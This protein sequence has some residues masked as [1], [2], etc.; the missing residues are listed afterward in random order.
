MATEGLQNDEKGEEIECNCPRGK[1]HHFECP[2]YNPDVIYII[3]TKDDLSASEQAAQQKIYSMYKN[4]KNIPPEN[5]G[6]ETA[7]AISYM[8]HHTGCVEFQH[9]HERESYEVMLAI[10]KERKKVTFADDS[11]KQKDPEWI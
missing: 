6:C 10:L 5:C 7:A 9:I 4:T 3:D 11:D 2:W 1:I 8:G